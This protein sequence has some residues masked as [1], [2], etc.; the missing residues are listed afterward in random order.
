MNKNTETQ[1]ATP[2]QPRGDAAAEPQMIP[3]LTRFDRAELDAMKEETGAV[4]DATAVACFVRK[5]LRGRSGQ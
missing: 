2:P 4:A 3:V 1:E 5:K